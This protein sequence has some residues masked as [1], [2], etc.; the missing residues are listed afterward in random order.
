MA[1]NNQT[2]FQA[3]HQ[4]RDLLCVDTGLQD[5][6]DVL[7]KGMKLEDKLEVRNAAFHLKLTL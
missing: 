1:R 6:R 5:I 4:K 2:S 7:A 3:V